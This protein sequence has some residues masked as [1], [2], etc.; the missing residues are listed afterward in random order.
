MRFAIANGL[1]FNRDALEANNICEITS[2]DPNSW[3]IAHPS[4]IEFHNF[5]SVLKNTIIADLQCESFVSYTDESGW[6][7]CGSHFSFGTTNIFYHFEDEPDS[8]FVTF[9]SDENGVTREGD[10]GASG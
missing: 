9:Y 6:S 3:M 5:N 4:Y 2:N 7:F 8:E 1:T 10:A